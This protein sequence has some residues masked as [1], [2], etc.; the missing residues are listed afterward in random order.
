[1]SVTVKHLTRYKQKV[2]LVFL[3]EGKSMPSN[4]VVNT[5]HTTKINVP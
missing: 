2:V 1:M 3:L 4:L 5:N